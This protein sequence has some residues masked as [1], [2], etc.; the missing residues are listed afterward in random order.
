M[1]YELR[2][3]RG[4]SVVV[5]AGRWKTAASGADRWTVLPRPLVDYA[6]DWMTGLLATA[7][8]IEQ[9]VP[10]KLHRDGTRTAAHRWELGEISR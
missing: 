9:F 7:C 10:A 8:T 1:L 5:E 3:A 2:T 6:H 4:S